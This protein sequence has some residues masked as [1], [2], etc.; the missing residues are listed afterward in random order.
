MCLAKT[1][2][3]YSDWY[4]CSRDSLL[5]TLFRSRCEADKCGIWYPATLHIA[6]TLRF[7]RTKAPHQIALWGAVGW[8]NH[9]SSKGSEWISINQVASMPH[10]VTVASNW[11]TLQYHSQVLCVVVCLRQSKNIMHKARNLKHAFNFWIELGTLIR[12]YGTDWCSICCL[13]SQSSNVTECLLYR[14]FIV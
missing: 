3:K 13:T 6:A 9:I 10:L 14:H 11:S 12:M 4:H 2:W 1:D 7:G 5:F 8:V